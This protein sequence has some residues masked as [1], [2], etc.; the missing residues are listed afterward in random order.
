MS[1]NDRFNA[2]YKEVLC[3]DLSIKEIEKYLGPD[4]HFVLIKSL[5]EA[6]RVALNF[7]DI[8]EGDLVLCQ[9]L[10]PSM[11]VDTLL[12][13]GAHPILVDSAADNWG[14]AAVTLEGAVL[15]T[16][17]Q[18]GQRPKAIVV[19]HIYGMPC[20]IDEVMSVAQRFGIR[21]IED[22]VGSIGAYFEGK[23]CGTIGDL[24]IFSFGGK[25]DPRDGFACLVC[26]EK[27]VMP[28]IQAY[29]KK[30]NLLY[31]GNPSGCNYL[32][33]LEMDIERKKEISKQYYNLLK[34]IPGVSMYHSY[35]NYIRPNYW[36]NVITVDPY[37]SNFD[38]EELKARLG[39]NGKTAFSLIEPLQKEHDDLRFYN[40]GTSHVLYQ[41]ALVLPSSTDMKEDQVKEVVKTIIDCHYG[42]Q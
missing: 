3:P 2:T 29:L 36:L 19:S 24:G 35:I 7:C 40:N 41:R 1:F 38:K 12:R 26:K 21:V 27:S 39:K 17:L 31:E 9:S 18:H 15:D 23:P 42:K 37:K 34:G 6:F 32:K 11:A 13:M 16:I 22:G 14:I 30:Y 20:Y 28:I 10:A 4:T 25:E 33:K 5:A 8:T